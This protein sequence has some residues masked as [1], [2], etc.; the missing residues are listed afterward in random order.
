M[1]LRRMFCS[2][3]EKGHKGLGGKSSSS[4]MMASNP[5]DRRNKYLRDEPMGFDE[6]PK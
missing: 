5:M 1:L 2:L 3:Q 4:N 6:D